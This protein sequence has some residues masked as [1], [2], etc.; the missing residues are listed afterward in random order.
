MICSKYEATGIET[1]ILKKHSSG[2]I[3][4]LQMKNTQINPQ[5]NNYPTLIL[6]Y[7]RTQN[8]QPSKTP[9]RYQR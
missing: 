2:N 7:S 4:E 3:N 8:V 9:I 5:G 6:R 1:M